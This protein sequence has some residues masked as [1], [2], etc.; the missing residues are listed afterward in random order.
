MRTPPH[1]AAAAARLTAVGVPGAQQQ[2]PSTPLEALL[3]ATPGASSIPCS[4]YF[5]GPAPA[6]SAKAAYMEAMTRSTHKAVDIQ[7]LAARASN[8]ALAA[9]L[10]NIGLDV[11]IRASA[12]KAAPPASAL[13]GRLGAAPPPLFALAEACDGGATTPPSPP[14]GLATRLFQD[15][16][17]SDPPG[18]Q[19]A[20]TGSAYTAPAAA[21]LSATADLLS[22]GLRAMS[23]SK[24]AAAAAVAA[25]GEVPVP[26]PIGRKAAGAGEA[27][28]TDTEQDDDLGTPVFRLHGPQAARMDVASPQVF[29][30]M[31][32]S[33]AEGP[34][35]WP[36]QGGSV[37]SL[38]A[39]HCT[40][41]RKPAQPSSS[42]HAAPGAGGQQPHSADGCGAT[43]APRQEARAQQ[44]KRG[45]ADGCT[46]SPEGLAALRQLRRISREALQETQPAAGTELLRDAQ[47]HQV[48][49]ATGS[50]PG[51]GPAAAP[52][53]QPW[54]LHITGRTPVRSL[55]GAAPAA[56]AGYFGAAAVTPARGA[57]AGVSTPGA[58]GGKSVAG[59][60]MRTPAR[61]VA[62]SADPRDE[63]RM[64]AVVAAEMC[65]PPGGEEVRGGGG[66]LAT[67]WWRV[68]G[69]ITSVW[70]AVYLL[71][72]FGPRF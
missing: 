16:A 69:V 17:D 40:P 21:E 15:A 11:H 1:V 23:L 8:L 27:A 38:A 29:P 28:A 6:T 71:G 48:D 34:S 32:A 39:D 62:V 14:V 3:L 5:R 30:G 20:R 10:N 46:G 45:E 31:A 68:V 65:R 60:L 43:P 9:S 25:Q 49:S 64:D 54:G 61:R 63:Q 18:D 51:P 52:S 44:Q 24:A 55:R 42:G 72:Q 53:S 12:V 56:A 37:P 41:A 22:N 35:A 19:A 4:P 7:A 50:E 2:Q 58:G 59:G 67:Q 66:D 47:H 57:A 33:G 36:R 26:Q 70:Q 13:R